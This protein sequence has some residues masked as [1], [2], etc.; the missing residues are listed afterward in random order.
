MLSYIPLEVKY[1]I[2]IEGLDGT[3]K[4]TL[5]NNLEKNNFQ[6]IN[7][8]ALF[9]N[10]YNRYINIITNSKPNEVSDRSFISEMV[11]GK[12][13]SGKTKLSEKDFFELIKLYSQYQTKIIYLLASKET[14]IKRRSND[15][16]DKKVLEL[17]YD[18]LINEFDK[19]LTQISSYINIQIINTD[20]NNEQQT[21]IK[22]LK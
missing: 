6:L 20:H 14:L 12:V 15:L 2:I 7:Q 4:T 8:D 16:R 1:M 22:S 10:S 5:V 11:Y 19:R 3:G 21:L 13:L 9:D 17:F 18:E